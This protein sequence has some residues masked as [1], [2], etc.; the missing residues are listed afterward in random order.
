MDRVGARE[1][2][3]RALAGWA[4]PWRFESPAATAER[5]RGLGFADVWTWRQHVTVRPE[6]PHE[7]FATVMLG[8]HLERLEPEHRDAYVAAVIEEMD[9]PA[10]EYVRINVLARRPA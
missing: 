9:G 10:I 6:D 3:A 8:S 1:P 7:Y 5:L 4:G 2:F